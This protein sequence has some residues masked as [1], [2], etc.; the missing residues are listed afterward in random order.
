MK[1]AIAREERDP[2]KVRDARRQLAT[3]RL[4]APRAERHVL[5]A[6]YARLPYAL[7]GTGGSARLVDRYHP[8]RKKLPKL[9]AIIEPSARRRSATRCSVLPSSSSRTHWT[10]AAL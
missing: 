5:G 4:R 10:I 8:A 7:P 6:A 1:S 9:A 2:R 3:H